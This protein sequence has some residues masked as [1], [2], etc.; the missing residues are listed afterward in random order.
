MKISKLIIGACLVAAASAN[1]ATETVGD[2]VYELTQFLGRPDQEA[3]IIGVAEGFKPTGALVFPDSVNFKGVNYAVVGVGMAGYAGHDGDDPVIHDCPGLTSVHIPANIRFIGKN[4][5]MDCPDICSYTVADGNEDYKASAGALLENYG[6]D[7][8]R[9]MLFRYPSAIQTPTYAVP[10]E[11]EYVGMGAFASNRYLKKVYL[12]GEQ[13]L[14]TCWQLGNHTIE[15]IDLSAHRMYHQK[16]DGG[17]YY[18]NI[19][20]GVCPGVKYDTFT[21]DADCR[22]MGGGAFCEAQVREVVIPSVMTD[23]AEEQAFRNSTIETLTADHAPFEISTGCFQGCVNFKGITLVGNESGNLKIRDFAF[24]GCEE[25]ATIALDAS[26]KRIDIG[27]G[28]FAKC[29]KLTAFPLTSKM[30]VSSIAPWAFSDCRSMTAFSFATVE[31]LDDAVM[32]YQFSGSGL[33]SVNWP[34]GIKHLPGGCFMN[35]RDLVKVNLKATTTQL[36]PDCFKGSGLTAISMM[37]VSNYFSSAF[38]ECDNLVR[39][40]FPEGILES[41]LTYWDIPMVNA[42]AQIV[43]NNKRVN[44]LY[45]QTQ[46]WDSSNISLYMSTFTPGQD[47]GTGWK[48]VCVPGR[49]EDIYSALTDDEVVPMYSYT[50]YHDEKAVEVVSLMPEVKIKGVT[51]EGVEAILRSGRWV[52]DDAVLADGKMNVTVNYTVNNNVMT[53]SY[54][55]PYEASGVAVTAIDVNEPQIIVHLAGLEFVSTDHWNLF[56]QWGEIAMSGD[57]T[58]VSTDGLPKG[59]YIVEAWRGNTRRIVKI[60]R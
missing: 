21:I 50:T 58:S 42:D 8:P 11:I 56:N 54:E 15:S 22:Y 55:Y 52:A 34:S 60:I 4:E 7:E 25:L 19:F 39:V 47:L 40:Y 32:G 48:R 26:V 6:Y 1:A 44:G 59:V 31:A 3:M 41:D 17:I 23:Y 16:A 49:A 9:W 30:K 38:E 14:S 46:Y 29:R 12:S 2:Y 35:C 45:R 13:T 57:T 53:T 28:A 5:F 18:G 10:S 27:W 24:Y 51:I 37:G 33:T 43:I 20:K 36:G